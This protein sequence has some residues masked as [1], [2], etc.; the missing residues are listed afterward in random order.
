MNIVYFIVGN[1]TVI[2]MQVAF[3]I[4]TFLTQMTDDDTIYVVTETP[5]MYAGLP[6]VET[7]SISQEDINQWRGKH[8]FFWRVK[9]EVLRM[10]ARKSPNQ[11]MMYL[12]GDTFL[13][14]NLSEVKNQ[15]AQHLGIMHKDEGCPGDM[16]DKS[17]KM[18]KAV[19]GRKYGGITIDTKHHMWNAG[20]VAIPADLTEKATD[21]AL[22]ICDGMLDDQ[23]EPVVVEQYALSIALSELCM[24]MVEGGFWI[25]HYWH[26]K[27]YWSSYIA[28]FF[29]KA[30]RYG[31][32][33]EDQLEQIRHTNLKWEHRKI[34][35]KRTIAKFTGRSY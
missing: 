24:G 9:I 10:I 32:S 21:L 17:Q 31:Y 2:H 13:Y 22:Q 19:R 5:L 7:I 28:H 6:Q 3:S 26:N 1:S 4:R 8:D 16:K 27:Y 11:S 29:V 23:A 12:D 33:L 18:W 14:G 15:L 20:V 25:G 30:Y 34:I 35:I